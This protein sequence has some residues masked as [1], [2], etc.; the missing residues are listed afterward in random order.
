MHVVVLFEH[1]GGYHAARLRAT[2]KLLRERGGRLTAIQMMERSGEHPW[3]DVP[4]GFPLITLEGREASMDGLLR[5]LQPDAMAIPGWG[6]EYSRKALRWCCENRVH[7]ILMSESK[8]DDAQR[9]WLIEKYKSWRF[10]R[11]FSSGLVGGKAHRD[12][13]LKLGMSGRR[14][15]YG[16]DAVDNDF[17]R[18]E[19]DRIRR[20]LAITGE[21]PQGLPV[22]PYWI[23]VSRMIPRKNLT[24]LVDAYAGYRQLL[25][26]EAWDL[27]LCGSGVEEQKLHRRVANHGVEAFVHFPGFLTY[28]QIAP[29]Y[30]MASGFIHPALTE[31]WGL[32]VNEACAAG[33]PVICSR[34][35][36]ASE[37]VQERVNGLLFNPNQVQELI[38]AMGEVHSLSEETR[39]EWGEQSRLRVERYSPLRFAQGLWEAARSGRMD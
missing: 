23:V 3:G 24:L 16:Y 32:V 25:G 33:L 15:F 29:W 35:L 30:G 7:T 36:G 12:Y 5:T 27:V 6:F 17:F 18:I 14:I 20:D 1:L 2:E 26:S 28:Q 11:K 8:E 22:R 34:T 13:L 9:H 39:H 21:R 37:L 4:F 10:V 38:E 19:A 31:Q